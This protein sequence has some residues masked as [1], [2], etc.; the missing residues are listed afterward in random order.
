MLQLP[1]QS[2]VQKTL[3]SIKNI[4][5][6]KL[7]PLEPEFLKAG[8]CFKKIGPELY[9][10]RRQ[11]KK[12]NLWAPFFSKEWGGMGLSLTEFALVSEGL[13]RS[14]L[15]HFTFGCQ[16]PDVGNMELIHQF[17]TEQQKQT[18]L[19][20]LAQGEI[21]SCFAMTEKDNSG[22]NPTQLQSYAEQ[23]G[24]HFEINGHKWFTSGAEGSSFCIAMILTNKEANIRE[25]ASMIL[26][27]C[28]NPGFIIKRNIPVMGHVGSEMMSHAEVEFKN[29]KVPVENLLGGQGQGFLLAQERLG[30]GRVHHCMRWIGLATRAFDLMCERAVNRQIKPDQSLGQNP[31]IQTWIAECKAEIEASRLMV[32]QTAHIIENHG[33]KEA[34]AY[35]SM[36]KFKCAQMLQQVL[37]KAIQ[38]H[39]AMGVSDDTV[40]AYLYREERA[41]RIYDGPDEVHKISLAKH[42]LRQRNSNKSTKEKGLS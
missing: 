3:E 10:I 11:V 15:G 39:G 19:L 20:P 18:Y 13:G 27:P 36:I 17:G 29:C 24:D 9:E 4:V 14:P 38:V 30:P 6:Q 12:E 41:S 34:K 22:A 21:R 35:I 33:Q 37:D 40:L 16:A 2:R 25:R 32:L 28:E 8:G 1:D 5:E 7:F 42:I 26:V 31:L 23:K